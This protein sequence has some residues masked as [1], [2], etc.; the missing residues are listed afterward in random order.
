MTVNFPVMK[1]RCGRTSN[2]FAISQRKI[3]AYRAQLLNGCRCSQKQCAIKYVERFSTYTDRHRRWR[4]AFKMPYFFRRI[5]LNAQLPL[6]HLAL[7]GNGVNELFS[8]SMYHW[9]YWWVTWDWTIHRTWWSTDKNVK[10]KFSIIFLSLC[11]TKTCRITLWLRLR[12]WFPI[13][14][15]IRE[16]SIKHFDMNLHR[17][18]WSTEF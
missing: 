5:F 16:Y 9:N 17:R 3:P 18:R 10:L 13:S 6:G 15:T 14:W 11:W 4:K 2:N 1:G 8:H 7:N 12:D